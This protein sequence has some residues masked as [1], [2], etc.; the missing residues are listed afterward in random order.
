ML[1]EQ[2]CTWLL[3]FRVLDNGVGSA[4]QVCM[5]VDVPLAQVALDKQL[6]LLH[7]AC[8]SISDTMRAV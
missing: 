6:I 1:R 7:N 8:S 5:D 2:I 4:S 3:S